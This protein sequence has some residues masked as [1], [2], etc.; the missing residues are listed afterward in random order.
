MAELALNSALA[1]YLKK[2]FRECEG[3]TSVS[4]YSQSNL[5]IQP[6]DIPTC[7]SNELGSLRI[8]CSP[9]WTWTELTEAKG[10]CPK[11]STGWELCTQAAGAS[12][13]AGVPMAVLGIAV[14][15]P[16][17]GCCL[18]NWNKIGADSSL[19]YGHQGRVFSAWSIS[20]APLVSDIY[21]W[22]SMQT[23]E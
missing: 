12:L 18:W 4:C 5:L 17:V 9:I 7:S 6:A 14:N 23:E 22:L 8:P 10:H 15:R 3:R 20:N 2:M 11:L 1:I 16:N 13:V 21:N 19:V